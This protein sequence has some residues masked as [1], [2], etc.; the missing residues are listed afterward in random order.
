MGIRPRRRRGHA[1]RALTSDGLHVRTIPT[2]S[3]TR[4]T[5]MSWINTFASG[6][7]TPTS[8]SANG[9]APRKLKAPAG[10][11]IAN[12]R[13]SSRRAR[14]RSRML[15]RWLRRTVTCADEPDPVRRRH[16]PLLRDRVTAVRADLLEIAALLDRVDNP[17]GGIL[18]LLRALL[19]DGC[20]SPL[21][22]DEIHTSELRA[23]LYYIRRQLDATVPTRADSP[24]VERTG[25]P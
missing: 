4:S 16:L 11:R 18:A 22:N 21:Y 13:A 14:R 25:L 5:S 2:R 9:A 19:T 7:Q 3:R 10:T 15:A 24:S 1:L 8:V 17:D 12:V 23:T 6:T 20:D